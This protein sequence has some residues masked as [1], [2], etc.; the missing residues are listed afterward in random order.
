MPE[1]KILPIIKN[2][3][4]ALIFFALGR[5]M[6]IKLGTFGIVLIF[7][8][9]IVFYAVWWTRFQRSKAK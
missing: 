6:V 8:F 7:I 3:A 2:I 1:I 4:I 5:L 9:V